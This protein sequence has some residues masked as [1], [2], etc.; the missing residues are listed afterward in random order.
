MPRCLGAPWIRPPRSEEDRQPE[1]E[2]VETP[3][4]SREKQGHCED[5]RAPDPP[6]PC[7]TGGEHQ[8]Q[9]GE[10]VQMEIE[11][12]SRVEPRVGQEQHEGAHEDGRARQVR[13]S[14]GKRFDR[15]FAACRHAPLDNLGYPQMVAISAP[16]P[17]RSW[18]Q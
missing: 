17:A 1:P 8:E 11:E 5:R 12:A 15:S 3:G 10:C 13:G 6:V 4:V 14:A 18:S 2:Q 9:R 16:T 7:V